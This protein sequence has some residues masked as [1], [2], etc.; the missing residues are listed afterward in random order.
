MSPW[1]L[2]GVSSLFQVGWL[3]SL[4]ATEGFRRPLPLVFYA[5]FGMA[6]TFLLSRS[7]EKIP[8][9]TAYAVWTAL[10]VIGCVLFEI[11]RGRQPGEPLRIAFVLVIL[12][13][14][15]GLHLTGRA[16]P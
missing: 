10:S 11:G 2:L 1:L 3:V 7:L 4:R 14:T 5:I 15:A 16:L 12:A 6:S 8:L 9:G 13:A